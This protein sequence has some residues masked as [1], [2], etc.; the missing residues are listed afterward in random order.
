[1]NAKR[2]TAITFW[3]T[4]FGINLNLW[5]IFGFPEHLTPADPS[6]TAGEYAVR[7][8]T[9]VVCWPTLAIA[10]LLGEPAGPG[11]FFLFIASG[12][13]WAMAIELFFRRRKRKWTNMTLLPTDCQLGRGIWR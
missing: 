11:F 4:L 10:L 5:L 12:L 13:F 2:F 3:V 8:A 7:C 9:F 6:P 1:M